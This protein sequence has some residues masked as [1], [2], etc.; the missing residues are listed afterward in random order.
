MSKEQQAY[1]F[2]TGFFTGT[3]TLCPDC[4][5]K[6]EV[7]ITPEWVDRAF[8]KALKNISKQVSIP[9]F[10]HGKVPDKLIEDKFGE[11]IHQEW[12]ELLMNDA[13][14][15]GLKE[16]HFLPLNPQKIKPSPIKELK[17]GNPIEVVFEFETQPQIPPIDLHALQVEPIEAKKPTAEEIEKMMQ[18]LRLSHAEWSVIDNR[19]IQPGDFVD[20]DI[21]SLSENRPLFS[22][23]RFHVETGKMPHWLY[24]LV[25]EKKEGDIIEAT[26]AIEPDATEAMKEKFEPTPCKITIKSIH[27]ATLL[28]DEALL[29][30]IKIGSIDQLHKMIEENLTYQYEKEAMEQRKQAIQEALTKQVAFDLPRSLYE[31]E[32]KERLERA[33]QELK[34][35]TKEKQESTSEKPALEEKI[36]QES[37]Q[38]LKLAFIIR[39]LAHDFKTHVT[40]KEINDHL[41][42]ELSSFNF[43]AEH[44]STFLKN[45][46]LRANMYHRIINDKVLAQIAAH[47]HD[48]HGECHG[49]K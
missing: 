28:T 11:S 43:N 2:E 27:Q 26:S 48:C 49:K 9:G 30:K 19:H 14:K 12:K 36:H 44:L 41:A 5:A 33:N 16:T 17:K 32:K 10:R 37:I 20:L 4:Q 47:L 23:R 24:P 21:Y 35:N 7:K 45:E 29:E 31:Q 15:E 46:N 1:P 3:L 6:L 39:K 38:S 40:D 18:D 42:I 25:L 22:D 13:L 8:K 34:T